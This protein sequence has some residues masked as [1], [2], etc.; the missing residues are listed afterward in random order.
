MRIPIAAIV[1]V[2]FVIAVAIVNLTPLR[3]A[4]RAQHP[5]AR[6][7]PVALATAITSPVPARAAPAAAPQRRP[8]H[9]SIIHPDSSFRSEVQRILTGAPELAARATSARAYHND[10]EIW[11][12][13]EL[14]AAIG[15]LNCDQ[16]RDYAASIWL[17]WNEMGVGAGAG[18]TYQELHGAHPRR[19]RTG[20]LRAS[21]PLLI[22]TGPGGTTHPAHPQNPRHLSPS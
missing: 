11:V 9:D 15:A 12:N 16:Q 3:D 5:V 6:A 18:V 8:A 10:L 17:R 22:N 20:V 1:G 4:I 19:R 14:T 21:V 13:R 7:A 2:L